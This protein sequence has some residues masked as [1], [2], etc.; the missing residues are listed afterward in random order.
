[1]TRIEELE[2]RYK[3]LS[4]PN[5]G[6]WAAL[7]FQ[8]VALIWPEFGLIAIPL[9]LFWLFAVWLARWATAHALADAVRKEQQAEADAMDFVRDRNEQIRLRMQ[10][11]LEAEA[12]ARFQRQGSREMFKGN[13]VDIT[14]EK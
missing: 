10:A 6:A 4:I 1:M 3:A 5:N 9:I 11:M 8:V 2:R 13:C 14:V 7:V 12:R